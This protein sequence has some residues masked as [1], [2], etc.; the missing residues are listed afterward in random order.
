MHAHRA[1]AQLKTRAQPWKSGPSSA[2]SG[3]EIY[4]GLLRVRENAGHTVTSF[5]NVEERPFQGRVSARK[6]IRALA[7]MVV[8]KLS[9]FWKEVPSHPK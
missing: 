5:N 9:M 1:P 8:L 6:M 3:G 4:A 2:A 7:P